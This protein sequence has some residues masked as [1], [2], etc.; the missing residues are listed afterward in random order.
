[1]VTDAA[2][3]HALTA[4]KIHYPGC[5]EGEGGADGT[6]SQRAE[7]QGT[8]F[9]GPLG[10]MRRILHP[11]LGAPLFLKSQGPGRHRGVGE[12]WMPCW[13]DAYAESKKEKKE[14]EERSEGGKKEKGGR[15][16]RKQEVES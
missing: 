11:C 5:K 13:G 14:K 15:S 12:G 8:L 10:G 6:P 16:M 7:T 2:A 4:L 9:E 3:L 1:M